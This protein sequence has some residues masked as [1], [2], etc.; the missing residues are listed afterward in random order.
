METKVTQSTLLATLSSSMFP[1]DVY[2]HMLS[3]VSFVCPKLIT[4]VTTYVDG[5]ECLK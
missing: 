5:T 4:I 3:N 2:F 1:V